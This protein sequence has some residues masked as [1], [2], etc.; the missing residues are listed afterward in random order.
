LVVTESGISVA[1]DIARMRR[2]GVNALL[3]GEALMRATDP[4]RRLAELFFG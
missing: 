3:V 4:G 1:S 2:R